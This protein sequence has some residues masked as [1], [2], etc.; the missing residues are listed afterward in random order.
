ML[1]YYEGIKLIKKDRDKDQG[2]EREVDHKDGFLFLKKQLFLGIN[3][4]TF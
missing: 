2:C 4:S 3:V 1:T